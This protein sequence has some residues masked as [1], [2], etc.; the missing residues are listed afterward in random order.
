MART[1]ITPSAMRDLP[2]LAPGVAKARIFDS[3]LRGFIAEQRQSGTTFYLRYKDARGRNREI[4][5]GR[6]GD[7]TVEQ[8]R[9]RAEQLKASVSMGA[10]PL[11]ERDKKR[12]V[13][14]LAEFA[15]QRFLPHVQEHLRSAH[16]IDA[17]LRLRIL[18]FLGRKALD[19]INQDDVATLRRRL[20]DEGLSASSINRHLGTVRRMFNLAQ[21]WQLFE[22]R[23]P[24]AA[25]G[26]VREVHRD[27]YLTADQ[28]QALMRALDLERDKGAAAA[29]ALLTVTGARRSEIMLAT[30][31]NVDLDRGM[32]TVPRAKNGRPRY[33]PLSPF[34]VAILE[35]QATRQL[36]DN[37]HVFPSWR[38]C[39][40]AIESVRAAWG[41]AKKAG[42]LPADLRVH[43]L[44]HSFASALANAG[45][46][47]NEIGTVLG[48]SQ[49][50][51]TTRYAHHSPQRL[52]ATAT[53]A[54][55][56]WN[57][58]PAPTAPSDQ[59]A[60]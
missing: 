38:R 51:T 35:R 7:L 19:E 54:S 52:I 6:L 29:L 40:R 12:A 3:R 34:A 26:M 14:L 57:L 5:L 16:N 36:P 47:L 41:R 56:A 50:S 1:T 55:N 13:P 24:A 30:W 22:G 11:A 4:K 18:P 59:A 15:A 25:P 27:K 28:T 44:R 23:N 43:D 37:P 2:A 21:K 49:L 60:G 53:A 58:L 42:G 9:K 10:D 48:H 33:I 20:I 45:T 17:C 8:A 46:P 32:L 31:D 39:G